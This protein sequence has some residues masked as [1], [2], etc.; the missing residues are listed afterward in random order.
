[1]KL[2]ADAGATKINWVI[3]KE[4][5]IIGFNSSGFNP[6]VSDSNYLRQLLITAFPGNVNINDI[7]DII[8]YGTGCGSEFGKERVFKALKTFFIN[9]NIEVM[10]DL[11]GAAY[12]VYGTD[13]GIIGILG[14][15]ANAGYYNGK[16]IEQMPPS[17]G[18]LLGDEGSG[19]YLGKK[20]LVK[21]IR[22]EI[23][24][25]LIKSFYEKY[26]LT[27]EELVPKIYS[28]PKV[29]QYLASFVPFVKENIENGELRK[30]VKDAF[31]RYYD[32]YLIQISKSN[33]I[34]SI[35]IVGGVA[36]AFEKQ[37]G[38]V[39]SEKSMN[40]KVVESPMNELLK[41]LK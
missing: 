11:Q 6:N 25:E 38:E 30:L 22:N 27:K 31:C 14:T 17:L 15:G 20:L 12:S 28:H 19:A 9:A 23:K 32:K 24:G 39:L 8:Y 36:K 5:G 4:D 3:V 13:N 16:Q 29:N 10:T 21:I 7:S 26:G 35:I 18:Y 40:L 2:L 1:M 37:L 33:K 34:G 41:R